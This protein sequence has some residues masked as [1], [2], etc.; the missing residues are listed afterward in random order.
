MA[1]SSL[2]ST[3]NSPSLFLQPRC[4]P[5]A[6]T[7][8]GCPP[9]GTSTTEGSPLDVG[10]RA[11]LVQVLPLQLRFACHQLRVLTVTD[12]SALNP[13]AP[14]L[15]EELTLTSPTK[16]QSSLH[17]CLCQLVITVAASRA[18]LCWTTVDVIH[19]LVQHHLPLALRLGLLGVC[20]RP[21]PPSP[22]NCAG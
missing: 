1:S 8:P 2:R 17:W 5:A 21:P 4:M 10:E 12:C 19:R 15:A 6:C 20:A 9:A 7:T 3:L 13:Q 18:L 11:N 22:L 14:V 16:F